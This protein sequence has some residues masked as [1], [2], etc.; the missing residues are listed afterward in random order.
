MKKILLLIGVFTISMFAITTAQV[1]INVDN[2]APDPS[3]ILDA[4]STSKGFLPPRMTTAQR[5]AISSPAKG[6]LIYQTD[7][8]P[9]LFYNSGTPTAPVWILAG[10]SWV[11]G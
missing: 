2:S 5:N 10:T 11:N 3:A 7:G 8:T 9:G 4:K 6:L 1:S